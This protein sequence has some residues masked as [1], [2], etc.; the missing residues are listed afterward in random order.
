MVSE[1]P[2]GEGKINNLFLQCDL[3]REKY[4]LLYKK[5]SC[6]PTVFLG[7]ISLLEKKVIPYDTIGEAPPQAGPDDVLRYPSVFYQKY[8][9]F[10]DVFIQVWSSALSYF[11]PYLSENF[12]EML[13]KRLFIEF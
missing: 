5:Y 8:I 3:C 13:L 10:F 9:F 11:R 1:I 7:S 12:N 6:H 4:S 2:A